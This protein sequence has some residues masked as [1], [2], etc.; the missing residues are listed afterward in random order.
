MTDLI[1]FNIFFNIYIYIIS[2]MNIIQKKYV[3]RFQLFHYGMYLYLKIIIKIIQ[4]S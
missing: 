2:N 1:I 4:F 3:L